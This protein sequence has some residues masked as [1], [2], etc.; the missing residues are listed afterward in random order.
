MTK[1]YRVKGA[2]VVAKDET[3]KLHHRYHGSWIPWLNDEQRA[4]FL[5]H[6]LV[7]EIHDDPEGAEGA[8]TPAGK[9]AKTANVAAWVDFGMSKGHDRGELEGLTKQDLI[10]LLG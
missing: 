2:L 5:R 9:P 3:G 10:E 6:G 8:E 4:H 7:E 1:G